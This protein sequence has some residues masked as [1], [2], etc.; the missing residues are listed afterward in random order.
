MLI[1]SYLHLLI[2]LQENPLW[3]KSQRVATNPLYADWEWSSGSTS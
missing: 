3:K 1:I 2:L